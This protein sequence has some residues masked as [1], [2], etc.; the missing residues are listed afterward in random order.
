MPVP[1][2]SAKQV[3]LLATEMLSYVDVIVEGRL[4][5]TESG[6]ADAQFLCPL[7]SLVVSVTAD[8]DYEL[9]T[10]HLPASSVEVIGCEAT[11]AVRLGAV[12]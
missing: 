5:I 1:P 6:E 11:D 2:Q 4:E 7:V 9:Q 12:D 10:R 3:G 8:E